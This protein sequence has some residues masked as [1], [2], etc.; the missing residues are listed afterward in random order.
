[1]NELKRE[2]KEFR[3]GKATGTAQ[4]KSGNKAKKMYGRNNLQ[5]QIVNAFKNGK[6]N[7]IEPPTP[8]HTH[9]T[10]IHTQRPREQDTCTHP[11]NFG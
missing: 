6:Q 4:K 3:E 2:R 1:M 9:Q 10:H 5:S 11:L 8:P 7:E